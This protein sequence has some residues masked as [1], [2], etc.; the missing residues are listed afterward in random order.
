M[1]HAVA[2][3]ALYLLAVF[4]T[5]S[6]PARA[7]Q[8]DP[9]LPGLFEQLKAASDVATAGELEQQIWDI[10]TTI[11]DA[12]ASQLLAQGTEAMGQRQWS[13]ALQDFDAL[14]AAKPDFAEGW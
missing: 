3:L 7:D 12:H 2:R 13:T 1:G 10:W 6:I 4:C 11:D 5:A 9:R 8:R 14:V